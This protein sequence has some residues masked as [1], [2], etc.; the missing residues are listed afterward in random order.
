MSW[1]EVKYAVNSTLGT[2]RFT[3]LDQVLINSFG[4][5]QMFTE[6]GTFVVPAGITE[7]YIS[8]CAA[9]GSGTKGGSSYGGA[10]GKA[11]EFIIRERVIAVPSETFTI[12]VGNGNTVITG[13]NSYSK[14]LIA[15]LLMGSAPNDLL[16][17]RAGYDATNAYEIYKDSP[18]TGVSSN[19]LPGYGGAFGFGGGGG[20]GSAGYTST[21]YPSLGGAYPNLDASYYSNKS[22]NRVAS[23]VNGGDAVVSKQSSSYTDCSA[24]ANAGGYGAGGG[25]G[26]RSYDGG[27]GSPGMVF[28]EWGGLRR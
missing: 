18:P 19:G 28:I 17:F 8:A 20:C 10:G 26:G 3:S 15:N 5:H 16:G 6:N 13:E 7:I 1:S 14:T 21:Y 25:G 23:L 12:I 24:G 11:G 9:G 22:P 2:D 4:G 27:K